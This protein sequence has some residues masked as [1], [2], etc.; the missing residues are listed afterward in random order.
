MTPRH[1]F[2]LPLLAL[3]G[4]APTWGADLFDPPPLAVSPSP[5]AETSLALG[6]GETPLDTDVSPAGATVA[7]LVRRADGGLVLRL[8]IL[9][10][11]RPVADWPLPGG[12]KARA[13]AWHPR[14]ERLFLAGTQGGEQVI[15]RVAADPG[16]RRL[17]PVYRSPREI[18]RLMVGPRPFQTGN[19]REGNPVLAYRLFFG[20]KG[21]DGR[22]AIRS[23]TEDGQ[24]GYQAVGPKGGFTRVPDAGGPPSEIAAD[25]ALPLGFHPG[26]HLLLWEDQGHRFQV[27]TYAGD[28]WAASRALLDGAVK[29]GTVTAT[30]NGLGLLHWRPETAGVTVI[31]DRG[32][33]RSMQG[34]GHKFT[35]TAIRCPS[36]PIDRAGALDRHPLTPERPDD[37]PSAPLCPAPPR[38]ARRGPGARCGPL[39]PAAARGQPLARGRDQPGPG[40]GRD[41]ARHRCL[42][43]G[44]H[45][46]GPGAA[47]RRRPGPAP[48][49]PGRQ[50]AGRGLAPAR[51]ASRRGPWP[52]TRAGSGSF[53][54]GP[55]VASR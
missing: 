14:G 16:R 40:R 55:R 33:S 23:I 10:G 44:R 46:R 13:L 8:W 2:A 24:R 18:R 47:R 53:W 30:P 1:L 31:L 4:T 43:R 21:A 48:L 37:E 28:H 6:A 9:D 52:G 25:W 27:A 42:A 41:A 38:P 51:A 45:G 3:L 17:E 20:Q 22:F 26:G 12:F 11:S 49:D 36:A 35:G 50:P 54:P 39:R 7:A 34:A 32:R 5:A 29:G 19:D 15:A